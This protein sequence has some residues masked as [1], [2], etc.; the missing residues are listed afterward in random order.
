MVFNIL[1]VLVL[2]LVLKNQNFIEDEYDD[3]SRTLKRV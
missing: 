1:L 3:E 2:V